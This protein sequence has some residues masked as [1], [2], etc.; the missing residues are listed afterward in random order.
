MI[1]PS[2]GHELKESSQPGRDLIANKNH[3]LSSFLPLPFLFLFLLH[4]LSPSIHFQLFRSARLLAKS[5]K[6]VIM[7]NAEVRKPAQDKK[8]RLQKLSGLSN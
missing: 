5:R 6:I 4:L 2:E 8:N 1:W 3:V 7:G